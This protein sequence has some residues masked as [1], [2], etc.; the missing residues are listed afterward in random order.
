MQALREA[1]DAAV[2]ASRGVF[3]HSGVDEDSDGDGGGDGEG[4]LVLVCWWW[5]RKGGGM[6]K[7][8]WRVSLG[9]VAAATIAVMAE[10]GA[11]LYRLRVLRGDGDGDV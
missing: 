6:A 10:E 8:R 5:Q 3:G 9:V 4:R 7:A 2:V 1:E 11:V